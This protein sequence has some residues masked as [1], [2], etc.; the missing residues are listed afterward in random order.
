MRRGE[1]RGSEGR[2]RGEDGRGE[3]LIAEERRGE[4][5]RNKSVAELLISNPGEG[6]GLRPQAKQK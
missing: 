4:E 3:E 5:E 6:A 2:R 1:I